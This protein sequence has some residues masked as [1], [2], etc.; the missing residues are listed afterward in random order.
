MIKLMDLLKE[1]K[2]NQPGLEIPKGWEQFKVDPDQYPGDDKEVEAYS[3]P[4]EGWDKEHHDYVIIYKTPNNEYYIVSSFAFGDYETDEK[5]FNSLSNARKRA[6]EVMED[7]MKDWETDY[8]DEEEL[9]EYKINNP[10]K[11]PNATLYLHIPGLGFKTATIEADSGEYE[12]NIEDDGSVSFT[13]IL[14]DYID[15]FVSEDDA[16][17]EYA[18]DVFKFIKDKANGYIEALD[19]YVMVTAHIDDLKKIFNVQMV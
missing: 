5:R 6:V 17:E 13:L 16:F 12:G 14:N 2:I 11:Y 19:D 3:A 4:M 15:D 1:Y 8:D 18:P 10:S 7:I 9:D